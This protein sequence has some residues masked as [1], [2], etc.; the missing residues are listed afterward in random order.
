MISRYTQRSMTDYH[1]RPP[2]PP[3]CEVCGKPMALVMTVPLITELSRVRKF[4][5]SDC[6][7]TAFRLDT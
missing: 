3:E 5:C 1:A 7:K 6:Q 4:E 2:T